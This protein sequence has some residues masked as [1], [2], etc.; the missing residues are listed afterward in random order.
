MP[1]V[2]MPSR[3][4]LLLAGGLGISLVT[5]GCGQASGTASAERVRSPDNP[6]RFSYGPDA[7]QWAELHLPRGAPTPGVVVVI[8]GGFWM[9]EY[10]ADLGTPLATDLAARGFAVWNLEYRRIGNGGGWP[11]TLQDVAAGIDH[12][13]VIATR[14]GLELSR[15]VALGHSAGG[16]L[17]AWAGARKKVSEPDP[18]AGKRLPVTG[19]V[20]QAG[21]LDL[22]G[23]AA[24]GLGGGAVSQLLGGDPQAV[25]ARYLAA[26]PMEQLPCPVPV[27]CVH[28]R[29]DGNVPFGQSADYVA[30]AG[31]F[32]G[33]ATLTTV[34]G[35]HFSL[36]TTG[37]PAWTACVDRVTELMA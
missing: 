9:S 35:D 25:P 10:G 1:N 31:R 4:A 34:P 24:D 20:A 8:H 12:L 23:A 13:E 33:D 36:I 21:V 29:S 6:Q 26:S 18:F 16:Q 37:T 19:V 7:S 32:G 2:R 5:D 3:R 15:V 11:A 22:A 27:R 28:S 14:Y 30:A 17:A